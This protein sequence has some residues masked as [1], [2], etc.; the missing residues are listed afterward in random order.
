[1]K[2]S[3]WKQ[4][5]LHQIWFTGHTFSRV[6]EKDEKLGKQTGCPRALECLQSITGGT[7]VQM[8]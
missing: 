2:L 1:M 8:M 3:A 4:E 5:N 6:R 7:P